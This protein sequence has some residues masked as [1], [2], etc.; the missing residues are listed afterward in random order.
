[1]KIIHGINKIRKFRKPVVAMGVFDGVHRAHKGILKSAVAKARKIRGTSITLT[2]WPHPQKEGSLY[3]LEHR[4]RLIAGL[5]IDICIVIN[6]SRHFAKIEAKDFIRSI[7]V[8]KISAEYIYVGRNFRFGKNAKGDLTLLNNLGKIYGFKAK[9]F[10][11]IKAGNKPISS[12]LIRSLIRGGKIKQAQRLLDRPV[13]I[14]G[15]VIKGTALGRILGFPTANIN[16]H[17]EVIPAPG[18]Y[19]AK[20]IFGKNKF[21]AACYIGTRPTI[22]V[23]NKKTN[24]EAH[25]FN[26][27]KNIYGKYL[28]IQ[29]LKLIR[30]D[31]KFSSL[32]LLTSQIKKDVASAKKLLS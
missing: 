24:I 5:G 12:T 28:E 11:I 18:I 19:A 20:I 3:S 16:P 8:N 6:F 21:K 31:K 30:P 9:G 13:S 10:R 14:L 32:A 22:G 1:M 25:I 23:K 29:F 15:T 4:L 26:F 2:F 17:H 27:N 7:L